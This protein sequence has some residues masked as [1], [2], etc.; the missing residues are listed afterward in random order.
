VYRRK[1]WRVGVNVWGVGVNQDGRA[2]PLKNGPYAPRKKSAPLKRNH[3]RPNPHTGCSAVYT[4][5]YL[6]IRCPRYLRV[7]QN[8]YLFCACT[9]MTI[10]QIIFRVTIDYASP[11][12]SL[13]RQ[14]VWIIMKTI[15]MNYDTRLLLLWGTRYWQQC[16]LI[17]SVPVWLISGCPGWRPPLPINDTVNRFRR[18]RVRAPPMSVRVRKLPTAYV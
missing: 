8:K 17:P 9:G 16:F 15:I 10:E 14:H 5:G 3:A 7:P 12:R 6:L 4:N 18:L 13:K 2:P 11:R 1:A